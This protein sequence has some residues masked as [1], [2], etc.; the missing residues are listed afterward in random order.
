MFKSYKSSK[1]VFCSQKCYFD[2]IDVT[3]I[4]QSCNKPFRNYKNKLY[5]SIKCS[6][7]GYKKNH[8]RENHSN[9]TGGKFKDTEGYIH[10][11]SYD[12][13][14]RDKQNYI[15]EHRAIME[16]HLGRYLLPTE[17]VHHKNK[18]ITDN[19]IENLELL[20]SSSH[21]SLHRLLKPINRNS[22]GQFC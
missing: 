20:Q 12:H 4:C 17:I 22:K 19:R 16:K 8:S 18:I 14:F 1:R 21:S 9:W 3:K 10:I 13:P 15:R 5:C 2:N 6:G 7:I 11:K